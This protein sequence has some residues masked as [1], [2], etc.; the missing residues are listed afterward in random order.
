MIGAPQTKSGDKAALP[1]RRPAAALFV[2]LL[3]AACSQAPAPP[4]AAKDEAKP[5]VQ[6]L[7]ISAANSGAGLRAAGMIAYKD[8]AQLSFRTPGLIRAILVDEGDRVRKGQV[9]AR[10]ELSDLDAG[11]AEAQTAVRAA[12]A[13]L[14]RDRTL[15]ER[16]FIAQ[17]RLEQS[18][19][20]V[21]RARTA[22]A[23]V[24]YN[25]NQAI[26]TAPSDGVV[27]RRFVE[28]NQNVAAGAPV[29]LVAA[30]NRGLVIQ[31]GVSADAVRQMR[32]NDKAQV[33]TVD[34]AFREARI[35]TIAAKS[36]PATN[37]FS[38]EATIADAS[39][40]RSGQVAEMVVAVTQPGTA[41]LRVP[42]T[43]LLDA[44]ADQGVLYVL[45]RGD[46][47]RRRAVRTAGVEGE[48]VVIAEGLQAGERVIVTGAAFVRDGQ[49]V[50]ATPWT[51]AP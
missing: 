10:I 41:K 45:D 47:A 16:G 18:E 46:V 12:E 36:D 21:A 40:L 9:L 37:A 44:R 25:R 27:L 26:I 14:A 4:P 11:V 43:A 34:G 48:D 8:E 31:A 2:G 23:S 22:L 35:S 42:S 30:Q 20:S 39:G 6:V 15:K 33:R 7:E 51:T 13:Q 3:L 50:A 28:P 38:V 17:A 24:S 1:I 5:V 49:A 32:L 29:L 19:L